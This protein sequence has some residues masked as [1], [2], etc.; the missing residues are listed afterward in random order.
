MPGHYGVI[1]PDTSVAEIDAMDDEALSRRIDHEMA[2]YQDGANINDL[3]WLAALL[4]T[5][6]GRME[7]Q[8]NARIWPRPPG[9]NDM[10]SGFF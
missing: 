10:V 5:A 3:R 8:P 1:L 2:R 9:E 6:A 4:C 7:A